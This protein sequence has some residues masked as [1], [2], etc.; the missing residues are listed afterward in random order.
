MYPFDHAPVWR[1]NKVDIAAAAA[2]LAAA[3][4]LTSPTKSSAPLIELK[5]N[6][7]DALTTSLVTELASKRRNEEA[8]YYSQEEILTGSYSEKY[9]EEE[10]NNHIGTVSLRDSDLPKNN[11]LDGMQ[12]SDIGLVPG[13]GDSDTVLNMMLGIRELIYKKA[14]II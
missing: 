13:G 1:V 12:T 4:P 5:T 11:K 10:D 7:V 9:I 14:E 6:T 3:E 8:A 2:A